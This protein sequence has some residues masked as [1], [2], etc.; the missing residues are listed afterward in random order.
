MSK[1]L[2]SVAFDQLRHYLETN[3]LLLEAEFGI[4]SGR[5]TQEAITL[6]ADDLLKAKDEGLFSGFLISK[7]PLIQFIMV[8]YC[9]KMKK[10]GISENCLSWFEDYL[11]GRTQSV[12]V[13]TEVSPPS[14]C[15]R[16]VPQGSKLGPLL[17]VLY[18]R[19]LADVVTNCKL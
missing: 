18:T 3:Q 13:G 2:E 17:F 6:L 14:S 19:D 8:V 4:R 16:G 9:A 11:H 10:L 12:R 1:I 15:K 7:R 5:S